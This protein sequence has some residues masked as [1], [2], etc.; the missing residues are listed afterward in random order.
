MEG[1]RNVVPYRTMPRDAVEDL[2]EISAMAA[3]ARQRRRRASVGVGGVMAA[4]CLGVLAVSSV[5][6]RP[7][8]VVCHRV[9]VQWE[10]APEAPPSSWT[11][12]ETR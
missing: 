2:H 1:V 8:R 5:S 7:A 12:C 3:E 6:A 9:V 10:N 11:R 4:C